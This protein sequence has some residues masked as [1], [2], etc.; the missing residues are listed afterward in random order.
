MKAKFPVHGRLD[1]AA[2]IVKGTVTI[3]RLSGIFEVRPHRRRRVYRLPLSAVADIVVERIIHAEERERNA[4]KRK[5]SKR[6]SR[7]KVGR[8]V[9]RR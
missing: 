9:L 5:A 8:G 3:D 6:K 7:Y 1:M 4:K 2:K